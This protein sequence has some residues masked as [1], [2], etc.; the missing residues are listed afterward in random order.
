MQMQKVINTIVSYHELY[1]S[2]LTQAQVAR[3]NWSVALGVQI[4]LKK[5][6]QKT[7]DVFWHKLPADIQK[8]QHTLRIPGNTKYNHHLLRRDIG[9]TINYI[10]KYYNDWGKI[11]L[12]RDAYLLYIKYYALVKRNDAIE[13]FYKRKNIIGDNNGPL[14]MQVIDSIY[15]AFNK[16]VN[17]SE[18]RKNFFSEFEK[19]KKLFNQIRKNSIFMLENTDVRDFIAHHKKII[20][21]DTGTQGGLALPLTH[22]L[23]EYRIQSDFFLYTCYPW[24][25]SFYRNNAFTGNMKLLQLLE[26]ES[27]KLYSQDHE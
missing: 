27:A 7:K 3:E 12:S 5:L 11:F 22:F 26:S 4:L 21:I 14:Y 20:V 17:Y 15:G 23:E 1:S 6:S 2:T 19:R 8:Y 9:L 24:L 16:S 13:L 10:V 25:Y 18:F